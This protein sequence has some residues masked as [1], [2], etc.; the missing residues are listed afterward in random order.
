M[1]AVP[2]PATQAAAW[3]QALDH[4]LAQ[5]N[6][7]GAAALFH[8]EGHWRDIL[9][10]TWSLANAAGR[11]AIAAALRAALPQAHPVGLRLAPGRTPPREVTRAGRRVVEAILAFETAA[12]VCAAVARLVPDLQAPSGLVAWTLVT[13]LEELHGHPEPSH[14]RRSGHPD[15]HRDFGGEN[16]MDKRD[17]AARFEDR[18][19]TV[20]VVGGGQAGLG[21]AARLKALGV[22]TLVIDR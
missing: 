17:R 5:G 6:A 22:D 4:A 14:A 10:L 18:D 3:T 15:Y 1:D 12:G 20:L 2:S 7:T 13:T 9:A 21:I 16:W 8:A 11:P 19:P